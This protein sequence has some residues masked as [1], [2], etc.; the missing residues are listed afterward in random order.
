[1]GANQPN[2]LQRYRGK[3]RSFYPWYPRYGRGSGSVPIGEAA[4]MKLNSAIKK[5]MGT[6]FSWVGGGFV[7]K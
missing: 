4:M 2:E 3:D 5:S 1:M 6:S 7:S